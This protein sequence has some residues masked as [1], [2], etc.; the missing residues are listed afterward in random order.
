MNVS[1]Q[2]KP[3]TKQRLALCRDVAAREE[4]EAQSVSLVYAPAVTRT[5]K[6]NESQL[7]RRLNELISN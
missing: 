7:G 1:N 3:T 2:Y 6:I 4:R 5:L